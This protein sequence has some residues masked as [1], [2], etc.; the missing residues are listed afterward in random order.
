[1]KVSRSRSFVKA[2]TYRF[3][4]TFTSWLVVFF[5][6]QKGDLATLIAFW[7]TIIKIFVY[8]GHERFWNLIKWGRIQ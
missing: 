2:I 5:F 7:E 6:T 4:G 1:M 3:W 8:Y